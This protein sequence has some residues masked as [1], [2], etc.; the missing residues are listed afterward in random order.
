MSSVALAAFAFLSASC[1]KTTYTQN[2]PFDPEK[3]ITDHGFSIQS[4]E[5]VVPTRNS[6]GSVES[7][8][9][10]TITTSTTNDWEALP[11]HWRDDLEKILGF[12][13]NEKFP[14]PAIR[15]KGE[16]FEGSLSCAVDGISDEMQISLKPDEATKQV[17]YRISVKGQMAKR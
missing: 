15:K 5:Q 4:R 2:F 12:K 3:T 9:K 7:V 14:S 11:G 13:P 6:D 16:P 8:W 17:E 10:G 1:T